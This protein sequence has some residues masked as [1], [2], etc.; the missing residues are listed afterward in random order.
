MLVVFAS[1]L[2]VDFN[3]IKQQAILEFPEILNDLSTTKSLI[4]LEAVITKWGVV[5]Y[6]EAEFDEATLQAQ[7]LTLELEAKNQKEL[8]ECICCDDIQPIQLDEEELKESMRDDICQLLSDDDE[9]LLFD[10]IDK[11]E[12]DQLEDEIKALYPENPFDI[13]AVKDMMDCMTNMKDSATRTSALMKLENETN[14]MYVQLE[15]LSYNLEI[16]RKYYKKK[17]EVLENRTN[18]FDTLIKLKRQLD[19]DVAST[20]QIK[21]DKE[22]DY[23]LKFNGTSYTQQQIN[24]SKTEF[25]TAKGVYEAKLQELEDTK[26]IINN[27]RVGTGSGTD[28][29]NIQFVSELDFQ[30]QLQS[31]F[32]SSGNSTIAAFSSKAEIQ[33]GTTGDPVTRLKVKYNFSDPTNILASHPKLFLNGTNE[34]TMESHDPNTTFHGILYDSFYNI[35]ADLNLFFTDQERGLST[36]NNDIDAD[37]K[38]T[39]A[40]TVNGKNIASLNTFK[41]FHSNF[42]ENW[43]IKKQ[44]VLNSTVLPSLENVTKGL[45]VTAEKEVLMYLSYGQVYT[46]LIN[47]SVDLLLTP[48]NKIRAA[49]T[50]YLLV[51]NDLETAKTLVLNKLTSIRKDIE[52]EKQTFSN[53][54]CALRSLAAG[55]E[56]NDNGNDP[57]GVVSLKKMNPMKPNPTKMCYWVKFAKLATTVNLLPIFWPIGIVIPTAAGLIKIP[58]PIIWIPLAVI[59]LQIGTFVIFIGQCGL[60]PSP[61][62][63]YIGPNDEKKFLVSLRPG[64]DFGSNASDGIFKIAGVDV[65]PIPGIAKLSKMNDLVQDFKLPGLPSLPKLQNGDSLDSVF[66]DFTDKIIKKINKIGLPAEPP[67]LRS[68]KK[69][70]KDARNKIGTFPSKEEKIEAVKI[71]IGDFLDKMKLPEIKLPKDQSKINPKPPSILSIVDK[72]KF[73]GSM[74]LSDF[75]FPGGEKDIDLLAKLKS[76]ISG[77]DESTVEDPSVDA[78]DPNGTINEEKYQRYVS[79][80]KAGLSKAFEYSKEG[81]TPVALGIVAQAAS[82]GVTFF[83]PYQCKPQAKGIS[84]PP[85]PPIVTAGI[86]AVS[87]AMYASLNLST[88]ELEILNGG[89]IKKGDFAKL[90]LKLLDKL[91]NGNFKV[92]NPS[93]I[94]VKDMLKDSI[95][96]VGAMQI[97]SVP[98]GIPQL[99]ITIPGDALK[100]SLK[101]GINKTLDDV[102]ILSKL[103][104]FDNLDKLSMVDFKQI[105]INVVEQSMGSVK[106]II[107]PVVQTIGAFGA[108]KDKSVSEVLGLKKVNV[109]D[110]T[111]VIDLAKMDIAFD[112]LKLMSLTPWPAAAV[113]TS[114][115]QRM[116]PIL[117]YDDL[118]PW[119]RLSL[120]NFLFVCFLG[121]FCSQGKKCAGFF[122]NP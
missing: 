81:L 97:P 85:V 27:E 84:V 25:D 48:I 105:S 45:M 32:S 33:S 23:N 39:G 66:D 100:G 19:L 50:N 58:L 118:P 10:D 67:A 17:L 98:L 35:Y 120:N 28:I 89:S 34:V 62:V 86:I 57:L 74:S 60:C 70:M 65:F 55:P 83:S 43:K 46:N 63:L 37:V 51:M 119:E 21:T 106:N 5:L 75:K 93:V 52:L 99:S 6:V 18:T 20:L 29:L 92:P 122:E 69:R 110:L 113:A 103:V 3:T 76:K 115:F 91:P 109:S 61:F 42:D 87:L 1:N 95:K 2:N 12:L 41:E 24:L 4:D 47:E 13:P 117:K 7:K 101:E 16:F 90:G 54:P 30:N 56:E 31:L 78:Q 26:L 38:G 44:Q 82:S 88:R 8:D 121:Q 80:V 107:S 22:A 14:L 49:C 11:I 73:A 40:E 111:P 53:V 102:N 59:P 94:N 108:M 96:K 9:P 116:H 77:F 72:I 64:Q 114:V 15:E 79:K 71:C 104:D 68:I 36:N 112:Y